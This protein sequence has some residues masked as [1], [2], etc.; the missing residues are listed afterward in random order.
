MPAYSTATLEVLIQAL[1]VNPDPAIGPAL[2]AALP[3][4]D[5]AAIHFIAAGLLDRPNPEGK[6]GLILFFH[7]L[8]DDIQSHIIDRVD[9]LHGPLGEAAAFTKPVSSDSSIFQGALNAIRIIAAARSARSAHILTEQLRHPAPE[10][11]RLAAETLLELAKW[12]MGI[13]GGADEPTAS[14]QSATVDSAPPSSAIPPYTTRRAS[15]RE[16]T[17]IQTA[18]EDAVDA[19]RFH[20]EP[21]VLHALLALCTRS[22][23]RVFRLLAVEKHAALPDLR[24]IIAGTNA[25]LA[26]AAVP[27]LLRVAT[28]RHA[29]LMAIRRAAANGTMG[30]LLQG[31][32]LFLE[33]PAAWPISKLEAPETL[34]PADSQGAVLTPSQARGLA[35]WIM[36]LPLEPARQIEALAKLNRLSDPLARL[37]ALRALMQFPDSHAAPNVAGATSPTD[38]VISSFCCDPDP[39][40]ARVALRHLWRRR[41]DGLPRVLAQ[42]INS[43]DNQLR[44]L[45]GE[46]L[47]PVGFERLWQAWPRLEE[48][49]RLAAGRALIKINPHFHSQLADRL[50]SAD[51]PTRLRA[52]AIIHGLNQGPLFAEA[53][54]T[55]AMDSNTVIAASAVRALGSVDSPHVVAALETALTHHDSRVRANAVEALEQI[56]ATG[57]VAKL[58]AM[59]GREDN[60]PRANAIRALMEVRTGEALE[61]LRQMLVDDRPKQRISGLWLVETLG[62]LNVARQ[63]AEMSITDPNQQVKKRAGR[64]IHHL[65]EAGRAEPIPASG[66]VPELAAE[67]PAHA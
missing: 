51:R 1:T 34:I 67:A 27:V 63:V 10:V 32:H 50:A 16:P 13:D 17:L 61:A 35:R 7:R 40:I 37:S 26:R 65:I 48:L 59:A 5:P 55:L 11:R 52:M 30:G 47:S 15:G 9:D 53:L 33:S 45:A 54:L 44:T 62:V 24:R 64:V 58:L 8:P 60:R 2:A 66:S 28:L 6:V 57:H 56:H 4:A 43:D 39:A 42:L 21:A 12:V 38:A 41:W 18:V 22:M 3:T 14:D 20:R 25:P 29:A 36:A 19:Y 46:Y 31:T 23:P 49:Q